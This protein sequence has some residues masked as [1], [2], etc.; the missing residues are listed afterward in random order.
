[1]LWGVS[2]VVMEF[3]L[4]TR[5][6]EFDP[7]TNIKKLGVVVCACNLNTR[8][9][10]LLGLASWQLA[11]LVYFRPVR[12]PVSN[13]KSKSNVDDAYRATPEIVSWPSYTCVH[14]HAHLHAH[15]KR[16]YQEDSK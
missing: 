2:L 10:D 9:I 3:A 4:Q 14:K 13:N 11:Y 8:G 12:N 7:Q 5:G 16:S 6:T 15:T 1:M